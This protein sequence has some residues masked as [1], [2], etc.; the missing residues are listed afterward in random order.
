M[1]SD[2]STK[3]HW[4]LWR[5]FVGKRSR[6]SYTEEFRAEAVALIDKQG[7][8]V[9]EASRRLGIHRTQLNR[10]RQA[11]NLGPEGHVQRGDDGRD[12]ELRRLREEVRKLLMERE[13]LKKATAFFANEPN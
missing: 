9:A 13:I 8:T 4:W 7:Y 10:W 12:A 3:P 5:C 6:R 1:E 11:A 2:T